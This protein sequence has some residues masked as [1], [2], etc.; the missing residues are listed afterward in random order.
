MPVTVRQMPPSAIEAPGSGGAPAA[1]IDTASRIISP[2]SVIV[3]TVPT[4]VTMPVNNAQ[5]TF[6]N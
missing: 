5:R 6:M 1:S 4:E 3:F 2:C